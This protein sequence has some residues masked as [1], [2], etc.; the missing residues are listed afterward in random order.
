M[1][2]GSISNTRSSQ[3]CLLLSK[4]RL[5]FK[6]HPPHV[7][8]TWSQM[9]VQGQLLHGEAHWSHSL[10]SPLVGDLKV[11]PFLLLIEASATCLLL[12]FLVGQTH[13]HQKNHPGFTPAPVQ[14]QQEF[15]SYPWK[16]DKRYQKPPLLPGSW[17]SLE[18]HLVLTGPC[19]TTVFL[20]GERGRCSG[21]GHVCKI[22]EMQ[23]KKLFAGTKVS[24]WR[25]T[26]LRLKHLS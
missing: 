26:V 4:F 8:P 21:E 14:N 7:P 13:W 25:H 1:T 15:L 17:Q 22:G 5:F 19:T 23:G 20:P 12:C 10:L 11:H 2:S 16:S 18:V 24:E 9:S 6:M 3:Y